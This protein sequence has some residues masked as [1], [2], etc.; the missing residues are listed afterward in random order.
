MDHGFWR[1]RWE[2]GS[3]GFHETSGNAALRREWPAFQAGL[4]APAGR[5]RPR[6]LVPLCGKTPDLT[7]L[8]AQ[9]HSVV[10]VEFVET[11]AIAY[12]EELGVK[13][14]RFESGEVVC[15]QYDDVAIWVGDFFSLGRD[16]LGTV[17]AVYDRAALV[18]IRPERRHQY[19]E[20]L[21]RLCQ[22]G[23]GI[24]LIAF[25]HDIGSGPPFSVEDTPDLFAQHFALERLS[26]HDILATEPRF[27]ERGASYMLEVVWAGRRSKASPIGSPASG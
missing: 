23:A 19:V 22:P 20:Q 14:E 7:W 24:F 2:Q 6:V 27:R 8:R 10:G 26:Q 3:I 17:D 15:Y 9:G 4:A 11:A 13:P 1:S 21:A 18:A 5:H 25:E 12:F 16:R